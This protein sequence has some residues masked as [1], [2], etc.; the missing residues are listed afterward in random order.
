VVWTVYGWRLQAAELGECPVLIALHDEVNQVGRVRD[1]RLLLLLLLLPL[2]SL[3]KTVIECC[4]RARP[5]RHLLTLTSSGLGSGSG[6]DPVQGLA[7]IQRT[8]RVLAASQA[9]CMPW[10][11]LIKHRF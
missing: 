5:G 10:A 2:L 8:H 3:A 1:L 7:T 4:H 11:A 6:S 9:L